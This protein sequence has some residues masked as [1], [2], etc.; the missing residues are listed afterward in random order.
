MAIWK[1]KTE[2]KHRFFAWLMVQNKILTADIMLVRNWPCNPICSLCDQE[3]ETA[4]HTC[5]N[6]VFAQEVW[7]QVSAWTD[8]TVSV[9]QRSLN[10]ET[11]WENEMRDLSSKQKK[12]RAA[13]LIYTT[14]NIWK[15]RNRRIFERKTATP[16][17]VMQLIKEEMALRLSACEGAA[18]SQVSCF[19]MISILVS[20][21]F[22]FML[23]NNNHCNRRSSSPTYMIYQCFCFLTN[24]TKSLTA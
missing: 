4:D 21:E 15:E 22:I 19:M 7:V 16:T 17:R 5:L 18:H 2:S 20:F 12:D 6:C 11:W 23:C 10:L 8:G 9:P 24:L 1:A 14:W 3:F 13:I